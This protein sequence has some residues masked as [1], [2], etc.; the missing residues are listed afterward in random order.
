[1]PDEL[2]S[3]E[4][5]T[6]K[7]KTLILLAGLLSGLA[8]T[9]TVLA[10]VSARF[11]LSWSLLSSGGGSRTSTHYRVDDSLGQW[12]AGASSSENA[13]LAPGFWPGLAAGPTQ[14]PGDSYE[15][16]DTCAEANVMTTDGAAQTHDFHDQGDDDWVRFETQAN[17]SY[18][19]TVNN[20]GARVNAVV[21]LHNQC[22]EAPL[23]SE[24]NAFGPTVQLEWN[25]TVAGWYYLRVL[26][27]DPAVYGE[28]TN[29][30]VSVAVDTQPPSPPATLWATPADRSLIV[31][32][33]RSPGSDVA[34]YRVRWGSNSGGPYGGSALVNGASNTYHQITGLTN[35][36]AT[37]VVIHT[38]DLSGN[39][40]GSSHEVGAVPTPGVDTTVPAVTINLP[41]SNPTYTTTLSTQAI[42]GACTDSGNNLSRVWVRNL[43]NNS[44][45]WDYGL[46]GG[47]GSFSV[48]GLA[49]NP[50]ANNVQVTVY[51]AADHSSTDSVTIHR[52]GASKGAVVV[53]GGRNNS[54]SL[55]A[56]ID[57]ATNRAYRTFRN[58]GFD[59]DDIFYLSP[60]PQD[61]D[62]DGVNDVISPTTWANVHAALHWAAGQVGPGVPFYLYAMDH[63]GIEAFCADG[64]SVSGRV[65]SQDLSAWLD[66]LEASS[67][68][69]QVTVIIEA[70]HSGSFIDQEAASLSKNGRVVIASTGR[71]NLAYASAQGAYFSDAFFSAVVESNS[72]MA[73]F[74]QAQ[75]AVALTGV[76]QTPWLD[77]N[78]DQRFDASDGALAA[79]RYIA[80]A[81]GAL[82]PEISSASVSKQ[83]GT[84][85]AWV[86]PG[87]EPLQLVWAAVY[88]P[89]F[90]EPTFTTME[91]GVPLVRLERDPQREGHFSGTYGTFGEEGRYRVVI[92][93]EDRA[94][95]Q[96]LPK[97]VQIG[98]GSVY[99]P[100]IIGGGR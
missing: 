25:C 14:V 93:A 35:G 16:D 97:L 37:Y 32:W 4:G 61:A 2:H 64:C 49:L 28:G 90:Q 26:Q 1:L 57:Y 80:S 15:A 78:G 3:R 92:Y 13:E 22:E 24:G 66:E 20:V 67:G 29:Y 99:L 6:L 77:D 59:A 55:Q 89:S 81:F 17:K 21:M 44:E 27:S 68:C 83:A 98:Q 86:Q 30:D 63:G 42:G 9:V 70:C 54:G 95:N 39:E 7:Q 19:I 46:S 74:S 18:V 8:L 58:A 33:Q 76:S 91:L 85:S 5:H 23:A 38:R 31:Q 69:D 100:I 71:T 96:A 94:G 10:Q 79:N 50:G 51:D 56:N 47:S 75:G 60:T 62:N 84:I 87:N 53:V 40:S 48:S 43:T 45:G 82:S 65:S 52:L 34:G 36:Q 72:L 88:P 12:V 11:D 41:T 73:S